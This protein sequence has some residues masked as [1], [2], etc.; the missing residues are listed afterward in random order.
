VVTPAI[1]LPSF[2]WFAQRLVTLAR[3]QA[4]KGAKTL[5]YSDGITD[6]EGFG[7]FA[8]LLRRQGDNGLVTI[9]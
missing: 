8:A 5:P 1:G 4:R 3:P 7:P 2:T 6:P 9:G